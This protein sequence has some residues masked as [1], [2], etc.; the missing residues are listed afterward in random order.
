MKNSNFIYFDFI[1]FLFYEFKTCDKYSLISNYHIHFPSIINNNI[2]PSIIN[3]NII[4][5]PFFIN[6]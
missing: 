6:L 4:E 3:K 1:E 5:Q 2:F